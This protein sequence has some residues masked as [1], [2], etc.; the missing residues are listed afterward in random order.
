MTY[1]VPATATET[2]EPVTAAE[3]AKAAAAPVAE[4]S[5][6]VVTVPNVKRNGN[7]NGNGKHAVSRLA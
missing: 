6:P 1:T 2:A 4:L 7:G 3:P 5:L